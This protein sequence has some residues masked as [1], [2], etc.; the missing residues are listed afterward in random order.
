M[1]ENGK[2]PGNKLIE[3]SSAIWNN[4]MTDAFFPSCLFTRSADTS[5]VFLTV[6]YEKL[7]MCFSIKRMW[8]VVVCWGFLVVVWFFV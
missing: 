3:G 2:G 6:S 1:E 7:V 8:V 4:R 5:F